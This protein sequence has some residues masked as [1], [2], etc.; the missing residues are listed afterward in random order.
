MPPPQLFG[1]CHA[2]S[3]VVLLGSSLLSQ[4]LAISTTSE[5]GPPPVKKVK[6]STLTFHTTTVGFVVTIYEPDKS[7]GYGYTAAA[8]R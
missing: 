7:E 3:A 2:H 1:L 5:N 6:Q 8:S 4:L